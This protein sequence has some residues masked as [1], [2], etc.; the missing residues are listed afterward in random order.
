MLG[1]GEKGWLAH[2]GYNLHIGRGVSKKQS[3]FLYRVNIGIR[4]VLRIPGSSIGEIDISIE[5]L[6]NI[7]ASWV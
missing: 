6:K 7:R 1:E 2:Q 3:I 4:L 5:I